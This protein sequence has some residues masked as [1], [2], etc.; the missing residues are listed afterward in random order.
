MEVGKSEGGKKNEKDER[1]ERVSEIYDCGMEVW[2]WWRHGNVEGVA[3]WRFGWW[4]E[5][6]RNE[7]RENEM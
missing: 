5:G 2:Y 7:E 3:V 4:G 1:R 6:E